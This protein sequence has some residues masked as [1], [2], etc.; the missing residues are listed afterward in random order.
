MMEDPKTPN[1]YADFSYNMVDD[2]AI[3]AF[4]TALIHKQVYREKTLFGTDHWVS[5]SGGSVL[6]GQKHLIASVER[7]G[8]LENFI[9]KNPRK[10]LGL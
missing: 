2:D 4:E 3:Q 5:L 1:V 9:A 8:A 10:F 6:S 7:A